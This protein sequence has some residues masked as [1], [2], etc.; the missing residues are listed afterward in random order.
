MANQI[1]LYEMIDFPN[2]MTAKE[3]LNSMNEKQGG[4]GENVQSG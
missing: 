2:R 3:Y 4:G 1:R